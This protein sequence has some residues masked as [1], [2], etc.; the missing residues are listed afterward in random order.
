M[1]S[2]LK[3]KWSEEAINNLDNIIA[4]LESNWTHK[5]LRNLFRK[6]EKQLMILSLFPEAYP[7]AWAKKRIHRCVFTKNLTIYYKVNENNLELLSI[8]D[9]RQHSSKARI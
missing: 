2:G 9:T 7:V 8:F 3:I 4:W 6:F 5:E 1:K